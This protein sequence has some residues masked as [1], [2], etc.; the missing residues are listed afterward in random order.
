M[1][2]RHASAI[3]FILRMREHLITPLT[4][5]RSPKAHPSRILFEGT[6]EFF[7]MRTHLVGVKPNQRRPLQDGNTRGLSEKS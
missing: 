3:E 2:R 7:Q 1:R 6:R 5:I 4:R